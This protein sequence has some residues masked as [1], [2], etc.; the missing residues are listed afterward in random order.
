MNKITRVLTGGLL[1]IIFI[2]G[3]TD[4][5]KASQQVRWKLSYNGGEYSCPNPGKDCMDTIIVTPSSD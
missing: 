4:I 1:S 2:L 3:S 5:V